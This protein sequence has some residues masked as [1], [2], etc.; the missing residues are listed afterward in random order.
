MLPITNEIVEM[1]IAGATATEI[2]QQAVR[3]GMQT[4]R[5]AGLAKVREGLTTL[6]EVIKH[7]SI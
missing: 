1:I 4:L 2:K 3:E 5:M 7:T 6:D